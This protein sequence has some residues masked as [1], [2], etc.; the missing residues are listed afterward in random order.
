M[1][2]LLEDELDEKLLVVLPSLE[3][4]DKEVDPEELGLMD[5]LAEELLPPLEV[6]VTEKAAELL[7]EL[8]VVVLPLEEVEGEVVAEELMLMDE[9]GDEDRGVLEME[10]FANDVTVLLKELVGNT[11]D[12]GSPVKEEPEEATDEGVPEEAD[13]DEVGWVEAVVPDYD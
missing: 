8:L 5:E 6:L 11:L 7:L 9:L 12:E 4:L 2:E 13:P 10:A 1:E 3:E